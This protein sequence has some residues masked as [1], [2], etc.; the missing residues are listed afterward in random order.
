MNSTYFHFIFKEARLIYQFETGQAEQQEAQKTKTETKEGLVSNDKLEK[1]SHTPEASE[2]MREELVHI[3]EN[4]G[5]KYTE[6]SKETTNPDLSVLRGHENLQSSERLDAVAKKSPELVLGLANKL[7]D[8]PDYPKL[9]DTAFQ[10]AAKNNPAAALAFIHLCPAD[11]RD[12]VTK[13]A[14]RSA[15][16]QKDPHT[17]AGYASLLKP[18]DREAVM[19]IVKKKDPDGYRRYHSAQA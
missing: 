5:E 4:K 14:I 6:Q 1:A 13:Q 7:K 3:A 17:A 15:F 11:K 10:N 9:I 16:E 18:K 8:R 2:D 12:A 19:A